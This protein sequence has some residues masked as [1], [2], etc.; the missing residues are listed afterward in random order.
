MFWN[1][2]QRYLESMP[3]FPQTLHQSFGNP[4][5]YDRLPTEGGLQ[6]EFPASPAPPDM[7]R[8][9]R[10]NLIFTAIF[11]C[12]LRSVPEYFIPITWA[13]DI[14]G[15]FA[16]IAI[17]TILY[18]LI[19]APTKA[20]HWFVYAIVLPA[21][22]LYILYQRSMFTLLL[23]ATVFTVIV[24]D[25]FVKQSLFLGTTTP[26]PRKQ[27]QVVRRRWSGRFT[28]LNTTVGMEFY[29]ILILALL[30]T[31]WIFEAAAAAYNSSGTF[32]LL[33]TMITLS[34][35]VLLPIAIELL[36]AF[37]Y[38][39]RP[40]SI[41]FAWKAFKR[42]LREWIS[43]NPN[44]VQ[45]PGML[46]SPVASSKRCRFMLVATIYLWAATMNPIMSYRH[47]TREKLR[48]ARRNAHAEYLADTL[49]AEVAKEEALRKAV[50]LSFGGPG[51]TRDFESEDENAEAI[52]IDQTPAPAPIV[53]Q[54]YQQRMLDR[55]SPEQRTAY[56]QRLEQD[57]KLG[58]GSE[59]D[60]P[61]AKSDTADRVERVASY[62]L[63][64]LTHPQ[65]DEMYGKWQNARIGFI[66]SSIA[67]VFLTR[68]VFLLA[69]SF[70]FPFAFLYAASI[71]I[72]AS[73]RRQLETHPD[74]ILSFGNWERLV[75]DV[76]CT[77]ENDEAKDLLLGVNSAD[78]SP[79]I[80]PRKVFEEHAHILGDS[81]SGKTSKGIAPLLNQLVRQRDCSIIVIDLKGD[82]TALFRGTQLD[83]EKADKRF[84]WFTNEL[85]RSTFGFNPL[86]QEYFQRLSHYQKTDVVTAALGLQYGTD[87]GRGFFSDANADLLHRAFQQF[88]GITSFQRLAQVLPSV[89]IPGD[90]RKAASHLQSIVNRLASTEALNVFDNGKHS[91]EVQAAAI[92]FADVYRT[93]QVVYLHLP[94]ALGSASSAEIARVAL[95]SLLGSARLTPALE[96]RQIFVFIDEFQRLVAGNLEMILQ[97]ARSMKIG[98]ILA[99]QSM[100]DLK[101][102]GVDLSPAVRTNTRFKQAFA[103]SNVDEMQEMIATSGESLIHSQSMGFDA[104][105][106][107]AF[108]GGLLKINRSELVTPRL[109]V[110]DVLLATDAEN[111]SIVQIRRGAGFAQFGGLPFVMRSDF[112]ISEDEYK[113]LKKSPWPESTEETLLGSEVS[114]TSILDSYKNKH[115]LAGNSKSDMSA[116]SSGVT[117]IDGLVKMQAE[118]LAR[119]QRRRQDPDS[120]S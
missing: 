84:R 38:R 92:D 60:S 117:P 34:T 29:G 11:V 112:H 47:T 7:V 46:L 39:R 114:A 44:N 2:F 59:T 61:V 101:R 25:R 16:S 22:A 15:V 26:Y 14:W 68:E 35:I 76:I 109:R 18:G 52:Q 116:S 82:D 23:T 37:F 32:R 28:R 62:L 56:M 1:A 31:P 49:K 71:R 43:Y 99:N 33:A 73:L 102:E 27:A 107:G 42:G 66:F 75:D 67:Y 89:T 3:R 79:V 9:L 72:S 106:A 108:L 12:L 4:V 98:L 88:P 8:K 105:M 45:A 48:D 19:G 85:D 119:R 13:F 81:G 58:E 90:T 40:L 100:L 118:K 10:R 30:A 93:P 96:R 64:D 83:A 65:A 41:G 54:P 94:S 103:A 87:Y 120:Q 110:N 63:F 17:G 113:E 51:S 50:K 86:L 80:V 78:G 77:S 6:T 97:T 21:I 111:Q 91:A 57:T 36:A 53:L 95:Y 55:M 74:T 104:G 115:P 70:A 24:A 69:I 20:S 5:Q